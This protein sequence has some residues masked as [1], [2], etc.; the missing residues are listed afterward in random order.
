MK[1]FICEERDYSKCS[2]GLPEYKKYRYD[3]YIM[4]KSNP[5]DLVE[6]EKLKKGSSLAGFLFDVDKTVITNEEFSYFRDEAWRLYRESLSKKRS[7]AM[8]EL[9][10]L[11]CKFS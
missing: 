9:G 10:E 3:Y 5:S 1:L 6:Y 7:K 2:N 4:N 8:F 11:G